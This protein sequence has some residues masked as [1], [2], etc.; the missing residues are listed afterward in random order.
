MDVI[1]DDYR[2][3]TV[4]ICSD[5]LSNLVSDEQIMTILNEHEDLQAGVEALVALANKKG[6]NDNI[7]CLAFDID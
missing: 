5:G 7:T 4:F 2:G 1:I 6:G 3:E